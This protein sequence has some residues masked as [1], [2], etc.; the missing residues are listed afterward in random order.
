MARPEHDVE[1]KIADG[2]TSSVHF[3]HFDFT[4]EH[5]AAFRSLDGQ[6]LLG[7]AHENYSH[8]AVLSEV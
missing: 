6:A 3:L 8:M 5:I 1:R 2:K 7:L 4:S